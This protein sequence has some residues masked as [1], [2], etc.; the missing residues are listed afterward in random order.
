MA[1]LIN[2]SDYQTVDRSSDLYIHFRRG[3]SR[4]V[5]EENGVIVVNT[6]SSTLCG[7]VC[8]EPPHYKCTR[9]KGHER[10]KNK[11][12]EYADHVA[13]G[14]GGA[15]FARWNDEEEDMEGEEEMEIRDK[16]K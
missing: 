5:S 12:P 2:L 3:K 9:A 1:I 4:E 10:F 14:E 7:K 13:H 11:N 6:S 8:S 15:M 16:E